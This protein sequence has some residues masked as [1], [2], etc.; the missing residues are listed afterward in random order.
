MYRLSLSKRLQQT[1]RYADRG[2]HVIEAQKRIIVSLKA[3]GV[4]TTE[5]EKSLKAFEQAQELRLAKIA[6]MQKV[7]RKPDLAGSNFAK[8]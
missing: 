3:A 4:D 8:L 1:Q 5:A 2:I 7:L 6:R